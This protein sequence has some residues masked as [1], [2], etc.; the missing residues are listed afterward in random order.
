MV[1]V[2]LVTSVCPAVEEVAAVM[3]GKVVVEVTAA[4]G[5]AMDRG[6]VVNSVDGNENSAAFP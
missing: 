4:V 3:T 1:L 6:G 2:D 5:H